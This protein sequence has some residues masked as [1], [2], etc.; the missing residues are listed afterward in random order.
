MSNTPLYRLSLSQMVHRISSGE[1]DAV[2]LI[3]ACFERIEAREPEL[4]A[5]QCRQTRE[6]YLQ[7]YRKH[8]DFYRSSLLRGLPVGIKDIIDTRDFPTEL[9]SVIHQGRQPPDNAAC[10]ELLSLAGGVVAGKTV[11]TEFAYFRPGKTANPVDLTRTPGGSSSGS[12]AAVADG[13]VPVALGSQ[14]A[15]S[16]IRPAAYCGVV[17]YVGSRGEYS[18]RG[19]QPLAQS[20]DALGMFGREVDDIRLLRAALLR[21]P[22]EPI[23]EP[24]RPLRILVCKGSNIGECEPAMEQALVQLA[25]RLEQLG[26]ELVE[27]HSC[28]LLRR[29]VDVHQAIMAWEASRNL[30]AESQQAAHLSQPLNALLEQGLSMDQQNYLDALEQVSRIGH[31]LWANPEHQG[32]DVILAPAAP[33]VAPKGHDST[34]QPYM[35]RPWQALGLPV[36]TLPGMKSDDGLPL[37]LQLI[38]RSRGDE[39]L[40]GVAHH[41]QSYLY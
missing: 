37:G 10:V 17:G 20:L 26:A 14:T 21:Q 28:D 3:N 7:H 29:L 12:A 36:I 27:M 33:G 35:S 13:M 15:A 31:W 11:T 38:G 19:V 32:V 40:L 25:G 23:A 6:R 5:W 2:E 9:G 16:V 41:I 22:V 39:N 1:C 24:G 34:G 18:L 8:E 30:C 4:G